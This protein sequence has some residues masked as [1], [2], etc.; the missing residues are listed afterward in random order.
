[1]RY[2][3]VIR[4]KILDH[5]EMHVRNRGTAH[6]DTVIIALDTT[7]A[8]R[9]SDVV[10]T[11]SFDDDFQIPLSQLGAGES[12]LIRIQLKAERYWRHRGE[13]HVTAGSDTVRVLF[14]TIVYP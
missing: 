10:A 4:Y 5:I 9:F 6:L 12:R 2:P 14:S 13:L 7:Y 1:M 8:R 11:P 3:S